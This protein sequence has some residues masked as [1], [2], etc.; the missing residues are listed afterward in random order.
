M[1]VGGRDRFAAR[2][3]SA[4]Y[5]G[6]SIGFPMGLN[7]APMM[8]TIPQASLRSRTV[9]FPESG[10]DLGFPLQAFTVV[11]MLKCWYTYAPSAPAL[12]ANSFLL[13]GSGHSALSP[14]PTLEPPSAQSRF[15]PPQRYL[16]G[17]GLVRLLGRHYPSFVAHTGSCVRPLPSTRLRLPSTNGLCRLL[18]APAAQRP[19]PTLAL[20]IFPSVPG[21]LPRWLWWCIYPLLPT[22]RRPSRRE[23]PVGA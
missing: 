12:L 13:R 4:G 22:R 14:S 21:P 16:G 23:N 1:K 10:S 2:A 9:G 17:E 11:T 5:G 8:P 20:R 19:F 6:V 15:A 3:A 18:P 7:P